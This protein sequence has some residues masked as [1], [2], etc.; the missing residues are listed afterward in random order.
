[1]QDQCKKRLI[2][3]CSLICKHGKDCAR[4]GGILRRKESKRGQMGNGG[5]MEGERCRT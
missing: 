1:M 2:R 5:R 3:A 4:M